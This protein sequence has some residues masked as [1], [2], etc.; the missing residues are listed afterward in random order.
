LLSSSP[1]KAPSCRTSIG[2]STLAEAVTIAPATTFDDPC[3]D[4]SETEP[5][6]RIPAKSATVRRI[7]LVVI[8]VFARLAS[9]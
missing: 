2:L 6:N 8:E 9:N 3:A 4:P 1:T 5:T 7:L